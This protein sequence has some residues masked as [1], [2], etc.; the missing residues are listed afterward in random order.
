MIKLYKS[1]TYTQREVIQCVFLLLLV[2]GLS[3]LPAAA[4]PSIPL[5]FWDNVATVG[6]GCLPVVLCWIGAAFALNLRAYRTKALAQAELLEAQTWFQR[7]ETKAYRR[8][9]V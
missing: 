9:H 3:Y 8:I 2:L 1:L 5:E 4:A 6:W 7:S